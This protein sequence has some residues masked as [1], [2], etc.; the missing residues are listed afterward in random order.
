[1]S[2][3]KLSLISIILVNI[4]AADITIS[5][6]TQDYSVNGAVDTLTINNSVTVSQS[7]NNLTNTTDGG[8]IFSDNSTATAVVN[9]G[10]ITGG[11]TTEGSAVN[12]RVDSSG[13]SVL[14]SDFT[15]NGTITSRT[16]FVL[17][18]AGGLGSSE[19]TNFTN[20]SSGVIHGEN[21][22]FYLNS[23]NAKI[24]LLTNNGS[25]TANGYYIID[26]SNGATIDDI[27]NSGTMT[28][29]TREAI[30]LRASGTNITNTINNSGTI[31]GQ[32]DGIANGTSTLNG[33]V[34]GTT[35]GTIINTG[36]ITGVSGYSINNAGTITTLRNSQNNLT[37]N[38]KLPSNY[39]VIINSSS[40]YGKLIITNPNGTTNFGVYSS[41]TTGTFSDVIS[42]IS[43][44]NL[45][46]LTG[47]FGAW[48]WTLSDAN[49]D[50]S[51]DLDL[52]G[53]LLSS[54]NTESNIAA[55]GAASVI[56][57]NG[58]LLNLFSAQTTSAQQS[59]AVNQTL[60]LLTGA[61]GVAV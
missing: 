32:I 46:S 34:G 45:N 28:S 61:S 33:T 57:Q 36:T 58:D 43:S 55:R 26:L 29:S 17:W 50:N 19:I 10:T 14:I 24:D 42:G 52:A 20:S 30:V 18:E 11:T 16:T 35:I 4:N 40:D 2:Y 22:A 7:N 15:N 38:N 25:I 39:D 56:D 6:N 53:N 49:T 23:S 5:S 59:N 12:L 31:I 37:L 27:V 9:N 54:V 21:S 60:P 51:W 48:N 41:A 3:K 44:S 47:T 1:M 13:N 8:L